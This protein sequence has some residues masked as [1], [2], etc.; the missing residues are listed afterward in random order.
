MT[1]LMVAP[2]LPAPSLDTVPLLKESAVA[3]GNSSALIGRPSFAA[4]SRSLSPSAA[5]ARRFAFVWVGDAAGAGQLRNH[6]NDVD[7]VIVDLLTLSDSSNSTSITIN[8][9][10]QWFM[11][12]KTLHARHALTYALVSNELSPARFAAAIA[13]H[14]DRS[15]LADEMVA[16]YREVGAEGLV[17]DSRSVP[18]GGHVNF[19]KFLYAVRQ[20]VQRARGPPTTVPSHAGHPIAPRFSSRDVAAKYQRSRSN[21]LIATAPYR[22]EAAAARDQ[23][24]TIVTRKVRAGGSPDSHGRRISSTNSHVPDAVAANISTAP[25]QSRRVKSRQL[26]SVRSAGRPDAVVT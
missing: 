18:D 2:F 14:E 15:R 23:R 17:L 21:S 1:G 16:R 24:A 12:W 26:A 11:R 25:S 4:R 10:S 19:V 9:Y 20:A 6:A 3:T 22:N 13:T 8:E 5:K 7:G